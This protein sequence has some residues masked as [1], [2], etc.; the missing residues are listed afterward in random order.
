M[1]NSFEDSL[2]KLS[3]YIIL[4]CQLLQKQSLLIDMKAVL[5]FPISFKMKNVFKEECFGLWELLLF[6]FFLW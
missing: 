5:F 4:Y 1:W 3:S 6:L 2:I